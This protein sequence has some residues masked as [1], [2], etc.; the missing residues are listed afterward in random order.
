M[1]AFDA[2]DDR[3]H[4]LSRHP[5]LHFREHPLGVDCALLPQYLPL[6]YLRFRLL[7]FRFLPGRKQVILLL[8][9]LQPVNRSLM[10]RYV[11]SGRLRHS[12]DVIS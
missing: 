8:T 2:C 6:G 7:R 12:P 9:N 1:V 5:A 10:L 4:T 11:T 3:D